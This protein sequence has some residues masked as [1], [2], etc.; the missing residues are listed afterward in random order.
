[1]ASKRQTAA[2]NPAGLLQRVWQPTL[3]VAAI[4]L[5]LTSW[6]E[7]RRANDL[8]EKQFQAEQARQR[9]LDEKAKKES[10][11]VVLTDISDDG[12]QISFSIPDEGV[13]L[14]QVML[15]FPPQ[16]GAPPIWTE[17]GRPQKLSVADFEG[18]LRSLV[19]PKGHG[20]ITQN[21]VIAFIPLAL[22]ANFG[23]RGEAYGEWST[24]TMQ[25]RSKLVGGTPHITVESLEMDAPMEKVADLPAAQ[26][27]LATC[28]KDYEPGMGR[29]DM[30]RD[31]MDG[32]NFCKQR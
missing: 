20:A 16:L 32:K 28:W 7:A 19:L 10:R 31:P 3:S 29:H 18:P 17:T 15:V 25:I 11:S 27:L 5:S 4:I 13:S 21:D 9:E 24:Y 2:V 1:M 23:G 12:R 30:K 22:Q 6:N 8:A 14:R 26:K